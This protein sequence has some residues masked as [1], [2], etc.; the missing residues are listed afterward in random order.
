MG[1]GVPLLNEYK[2][3]FVWKRLPQTVFGG[4][5]LKLGYTA[6]VYVYLSQVL[7]SVCCHCSRF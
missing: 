6:P 7:N 5:K 1:V 2:Q 4:P 3:E